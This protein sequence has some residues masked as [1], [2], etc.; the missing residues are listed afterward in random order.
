LG[1]HPWHVRLGPS[2]GSEGQ[3]ESFDDAVRALDEI[4]RDADLLNKLN[5]RYPTAKF[6]ALANEGN[7]EE[8]TAPVNPVIIQVHPLS[9]GRV[10]R[11]DPD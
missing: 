1:I 10:I 11:D 5:T 8:N 6:T 9:P 4:D 2:D 3:A 7:F